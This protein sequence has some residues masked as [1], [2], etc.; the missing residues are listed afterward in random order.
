MNIFHHIMCNSDIVAISMAW[1][2]IKDVFALFLEKIFEFTLLMGVPSYP[3]AILIFTI[4]VKVLLQPLMNKQLRSTHQMARVQPQLL[5]IQKKFANNRPKMQEEQMKLYKEN[6]V[7]PMAGCLPL[8]VQMP[9]LIALYSALRYF[10]PV[11]EHA[12][13]Y[14]FLWI[15][16]LSQPDITWLMPVLVGASTFLQQWVSIVNKQDKTQRMMLIIMPIMFIWFVRS[17]PA[18]LALYWT[19]Y[20]LIGAALQYYFNRKWAREDAIVAEQNA[21]AAQAILDEKR[22]KRAARQS[23]SGGKL[24]Q[25]TQPEGPQLIK[26]E[27]QVRKHPYS[28]E[29]VTIVEEKLV[30]SD[31]RPLSEKLE[32]KS[33][34]TPKKKNLHK[35]K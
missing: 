31:G 25:P 12:A 24:K 33:Q 26:V 21:T 8:L 20:S 10:Q 27:K 28:D 5:E 34:K 29:M 6:N 7:N 18:G 13:Y 9:I 16:N 3:L 17:L 22:A 15:P 19:F 1:D 35:K 14:S 4:I 23:E 11:A 2:G 30:D 32:D